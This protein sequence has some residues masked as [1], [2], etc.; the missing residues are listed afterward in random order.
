MA[1]K[2][3]LLPQKIGWLWKHMQFLQLNISPESATATLTTL[4]IFPVYSACYAYKMVACT[5]SALQ[6]L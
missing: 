4:E 6:K 3:P 5:D 1:L 2:V